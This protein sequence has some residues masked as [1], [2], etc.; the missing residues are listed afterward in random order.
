MIRK[1][2][3]AEALLANKSQNDVCK[4][5]HCSK[6]TVGRIA[7]VIE[8]YAID[9]EKLTEISDED[10]DQ[11][12]EFVGPDKP[13]KPEEFVQ[14]DFEALNARLERNPKLTLW[15]LWDEY[16]AK[17]SGGLKALS[18]SQ[19]C[20][21]YSL[22]KKSPKTT[23]LMRYVAG[24]IA[25]VDWS[26]LTGL[27]YNRA[28]GKTQRVYL[29]VFS[30]PYSSLIFAKGYLSLAQPCWL[31]GHMSAFEYAGGV[32]KIVVPDHCATATDNNSGE[33]YKT[34]IN[35]CYA[36]FADHYGFSTLPAR[37]GRPRDKNVVE[38]AVN[39]CEQWII[40]PLLEEKIYSIEEYNQVVAQKVQWLNE[41]PFQQKDGSR[42]SVFITKELPQLGPL[43]DSR[44]EIPV[45]KAAKVAPNGHIQIDYMHYS[46]PYAYVGKTLDV[47]A[48]YSK[49]EIFA[50]G[51]LIAS[52]NRLMGAKNQYSTVLDHMAS[53]WPYAKS[54]WD[55]RRFT[56]WAKRYGEAALVLIERVLNSKPV[57]EQAYLPC[58]NIL[59]LAKSYGSRVFTQA[60]QR[61]FESSEAIPTYTALKKICIQIKS[62]T[63]PNTSSMVASKTQ[64]FPSNIKA[65][66]RG[67][68]HYS[69]DDK[70][71]L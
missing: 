2:L 62:E 4:Q 18:Y 36:E 59:S 41:R 44:F 11:L 22:W 33:P 65:K 10:L 46:V 21:R 52:H 54:P 51:S 25:F 58:Q 60:C 68:N 43:P 24:Q 40:A 39:L 38:A 14:P 32:P 69:I 35:E 70:E 19:F 55:R 48:T 6:T 56:S 64:T 3:I 30:L 13:Q 34:V 63:R 31:D 57:L 27:I 47:R 26:G 29:F 23:T 16:A 8:D 67:A 28:S 12:Y 61:F 20:R 50:K 45:W 17:C 9:E 71:G 42:K 49:I 53:A 66:V 5:L 7:K 15:Y 37:V 1:R